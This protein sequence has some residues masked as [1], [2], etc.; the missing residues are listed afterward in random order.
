[1]GTVLQQAG[2]LPGACRAAV[3]PANGLARTA[4]A[5]P[6]LAAYGQ[7]AGF[8]SVE[9]MLPR[10]FK[11]ISRSLATSESGTGALSANIFPGR[12][13]SR[14]AAGFLRTNANFRGHFMDSVDRCAVERTAGGVRE[15]K[16]GAFAHYGR[17]TEHLKDSGV[18]VLSMALFSAQIKGC[19]VG[20]TKRGKG[21][22][23][24][25]LVDGPGTPLGVHL[26][27]ASPAEVTSLRKSPSP[28]SASG[29]PGQAAPGLPPAG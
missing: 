16:R 3:Q 14:K 6:A 29:T 19:E 24:V 28:Q 25:V 27:S 26:D 9:A 1:M 2:A 5:R 15:E 12:G 22:K 7:Q 4:D 18:N 21:L 17:G 23:L 13:K 20:K 11:E 8:F 10:Y